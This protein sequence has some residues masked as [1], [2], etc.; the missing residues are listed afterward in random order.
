MK[1][2][3]LFTWTLRTSLTVTVG[4][5]LLSQRLLS[6]LRLTPAPSWGAVTDT[7]RAIVRDASVTLTNEGTNASL[8]TTTES[9]GTYKFTPVRIGSYGRSASSPK[10]SR[11]LPYDIRSRSTWVRMSWLISR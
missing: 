9:D 6:L 10:G 7:S 8:T 2:Q 11:Q 1:L 4:A 5:I 3:A